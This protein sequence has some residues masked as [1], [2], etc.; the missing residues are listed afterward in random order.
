M[1]QTTRSVLVPAKQNKHSVPAV[2]P[3]CDRKEVRKIIFVFVNFPERVLLWGEGG[4]ILITQ[5]AIS[6]SLRDISFQRSL[7]HY[8][9][10]ENPCYYFI[11]I[12]IHKHTVTSNV[13]RFGSYVYFTASSPSIGGKSSFTQGYLW[14]PILKI[15]S[16]S[17]NMRIWHFFP[18]YQIWKTIKYQ[19]N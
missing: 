7:Y 16:Y 3:I 8:H 14:Q 13:N 5:P 11:S 12:H 19:E 1:F 9:L 2:I 17:K 18:I 10:S 15:F 4:S 6:K